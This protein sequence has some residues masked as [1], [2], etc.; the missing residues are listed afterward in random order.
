MQRRL[1]IAVAGVLV[2]VALFEATGAGQGQRLY[3]EMQ[4]MLQDVQT[5]RR[6][7]EGTEFIFA[8]VRFGGGNRGGFM[9]FGGM[10]GWA[11]DYPEAEE[12]ILQVADEATGLNVTKL[13]YVIVDLESEELFD[14]PF[15]YFSEPAE[16]SMNEKEVANLR[17]YFN[18]GGFAMVDDFDTQYE[19][20]WLAN[21]L[22]LAF[23]GRNI[24]ELTI[25]HPIFHTFYEMPTLQVSS[26]YPNEGPP[27]FYGYY[28]EKGRL[29]MIINHNT[30]IGD[31][32]EWIDQPMYPLEPSTEA[33]RFGVNYFMYSM[34]H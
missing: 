10:P 17:E 23:P 14:Y 8:R 19:L 31:F 11:H 25:D 27:K 26:P 15:V 24:V 33:L 30:D 34:T 16:M 28:D 9:G 3:Y 29:L 18:R 20:D 4:R 2:T 12:H 22:R 5:N 1:V 7:P 6:P 13:S 21:Q 32:W